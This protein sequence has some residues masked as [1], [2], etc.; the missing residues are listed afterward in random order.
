MTVVVEEADVGYMTAVGAVLMARSLRH[1]HI[2]CL[3]IM[4][5]PAGSLLC[6][7][8]HL[9]GGARVGKQVHFAEVVSQSDHSPVMRSDQ[10]VDVGPVGSFRPHTCN[11]HTE[12]T[13]RASSFGHAMQDVVRTHTHTRKQVLTEH[14][15]SKNAGVCRPV[16]VFT[17]RTVSDQFTTIGNIP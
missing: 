1:K 17:L 2:S 15:V 12:N 9:G 8:T 10:S 11:T 16:N 4:N 7:P 3:L 14:V 5:L 6:W 13:G